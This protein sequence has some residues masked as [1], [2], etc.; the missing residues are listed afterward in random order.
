MCLAKEEICR[1]CYAN[2]SNHAAMPNICVLHCWGWTA[3][4]GRSTCCRCAGTL[5]E[6][7][8]SVTWP[9]R[10]CQGAEGPHAKEWKLQSHRSLRVV[11]LT[12]QVHHLHVFA[13]AWQDCS[14]KNRPAIQSPALCAQR[15][16]QDPSCSN[17]IDGSG[18][19]FAKSWRLG[20][21]RCSNTELGK[22]KTHCNGCMDVAWGLGRKP[23]HETLCFSV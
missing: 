4:P 23:E 9:C 12:V 15:C 8:L 10:S 21:L 16:G 19:G 5:Q 6:D 3:F 14:I 17:G 2:Q 7:V 1:T 11:Q 13:A 18:V 22:C 20:W